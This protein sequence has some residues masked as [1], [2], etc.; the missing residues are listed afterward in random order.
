MA[1]RLAGRDPDEHVRLKLGEIIAFDDPVWR[2]PDFLARGEAAYEALIGQLQLPE[3]DEGPG[4]VQT[5]YRYK[6]RALAGPWRQ[7]PE[8]A[9]SDAL[10]ARQAEI[11]ERGVASWHVSGAIERSECRKGEPCC[12]VYPPE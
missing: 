2:Y 7:R 1:A 8:Q 10:N 11:D 9:L 5:C 12:G 4:E 3:S 6:T